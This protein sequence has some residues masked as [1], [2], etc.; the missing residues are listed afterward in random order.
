MDIAKEHSKIL[1]DYI[2]RYNKWFH[3][4][5]SQGIQ[6]EPI[7]AGH[8]NVATIDL[9][10][11]EAYSYVNTTFKGDFGW[12]NDYLVEWSDA[13]QVTWKFTAVADQRY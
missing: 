11:Q 5:K 6:P 9:P 7:E 12:T 10:V 13:S 4:V 1:A 3:Q 8:S 2:H